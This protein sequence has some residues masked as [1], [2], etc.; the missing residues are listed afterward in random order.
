MRGFGGGWEAGKRI[1]FLIVLVLIMLVPLDMVE[2]VV[3]ERAAAKAQ[4]AAEI[5]EQWGPP[6]IISG[7]VLVV[8]YEAA[9]VRATLRRRSKARSWRRAIRSSRPRNCASTPTSKVEQ[10]YKSIYEMLVYAADVEIAGRFA[11]LDF[12]AHGVPATQVKWQAATLVLGISGVRAV[13]SVS[14]NAAGADRAIEAGVLPYHPFADGIHAG[15]PLQT[16]GAQRAAFQFHLQAGA[17]RARRSQ[18]PA[19]RPADR[20]RAAQQLAAS[21]FHRHAAAGPRATID[22]K[23]F[24]AA[25]SISHIATGAPLS[26]RVEEFT[27]EPARIMTIGVAPGGAGRRASADR[28]D[29]QIRHPGRRPDLRHHVRGRHC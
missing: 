3:Q 7:P 13:K 14:L 26:W 24:T 5:G 18:L 21:R 2:G 27:L 9:R 25:W 28:P 20:D 15:F 1:S 8:P 12:A 11:T 22:A 16:I 19:A 29:R 10:R 6:Q 4:V 23:G 17:E